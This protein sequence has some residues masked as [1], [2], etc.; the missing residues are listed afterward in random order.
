MIDY[1]LLT[2]LIQTKIEDLKGYQVFLDEFSVSLDV[3]T[4]LVR[5]SALCIVTTPS[6]TFKFLITAKEY[7]HTLFKHG[8]TSDEIWNNVWI[9]LLQLPDDYDVPDKLKLV[10]ANYLMSLQ[11]IQGDFEFTAILHQFGVKR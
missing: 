5:G 9:P 6:S 1:T 2:N 7:M 3:H 11:N 4:L 8:M 10:M